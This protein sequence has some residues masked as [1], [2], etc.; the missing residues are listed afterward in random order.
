MILLRGLDGTNIHADENAIILV[1]GPDAHVAGAHVNIYGIDR[2]VMPAAEN[3]AALVARLAVTP[4]LARLTRPDRTPVWIKGPAVTAIRAP[5]STE[6]QDPGA[7][8]AVVILGGLHQAVHEDVA[9]TQRVL[10]AHGA[11]V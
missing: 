2:G 4:P 9:A 3:P 11:N 7:V 5:L 6:R 8:N 1:T 10:N